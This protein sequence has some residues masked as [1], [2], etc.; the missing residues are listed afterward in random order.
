MINFYI[1]FPSDIFSDIPHLREKTVRIANLIRTVNIFMVKKIFIFKHHK[2]DEDLN[3]LINYFLT[4]S[5][6]RK[7]RFGI[8]KRLKYTGCAPPIRAQYEGWRDKKIG[9]VL[10]YDSSKKIL[11]VAIDLNKKV[12]VRYEKDLTGKLVLLNSTS[13]GWEIE[14]NKYQDLIDRVVFLEDLITFL[15]KTKGN[16]FI[17]ISTAR[18]G[19]ILSL[20]LIT[21]IRKKMMTN[22]EVLFLFGSPREGL[23]EIF[24]EFKANIEDFSD[25]I[26]NTFPNQGVETIRTDEAIFGT[27]SIFNL[28]RF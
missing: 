9:Y 28:L 13:K 4:P 27:L 21:E 7:F 22:T 15:K 11:K 25:Y 14:Q 6:L 8:N 12:N 16:K 2:A 10:S 1:S 3:I 19:K 23:Y 24:R 26:L 18:E 17:V 20:D 5:Y